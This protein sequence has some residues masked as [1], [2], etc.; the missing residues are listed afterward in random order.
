MPPSEQD[1]EF[2]AANEIAVA[3]LRDAFSPLTTRLTW[4]I[5]PAPVYSPHVR[6]VEVAE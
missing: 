2:K 6:V 1:R 5:E 4:E 3:S